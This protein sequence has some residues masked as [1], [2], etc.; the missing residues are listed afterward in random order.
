MI[1]T[2]YLTGRGREAKVHLWRLLLV[3]YH[4]SLLPITDPFPQQ[5][6]NIEATVTSPIIIQAAPTLEIEDVV[7][8]PP[9]P[10]AKRKSTRTSA[11]NGPSIVG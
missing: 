9:G 2:P 3:S 4:A 8:S 10:S 5:S 1:T 7:S 6:V 11:D